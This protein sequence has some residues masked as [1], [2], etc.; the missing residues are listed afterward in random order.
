M[1]QTMKTAEEFLNDLKKMPQVPFIVDQLLPDSRQAFS[2]I[3]GRPEIGKTNLALYE[4]FCIA[5]GTPFFYS[6]PRGRR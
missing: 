2:I 6:R 3:C 5:T 1:E 4:A